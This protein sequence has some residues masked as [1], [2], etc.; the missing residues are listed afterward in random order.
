MA[1]AT[2]DRL[3]LLIE[4]IERL[5]EEKKGIADDIRDVYAEAKAV[6]YDVRIMRQIVRLRKMDN[7]DRSEMETILETY[8][9]A[10]GMG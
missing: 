9:A 3:R 1:D 6:G 4:R 8:K 10:L 2:D 7:N 5:E